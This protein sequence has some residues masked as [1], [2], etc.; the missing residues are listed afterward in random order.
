VGDTIS[1]TDTP[2]HELR[3][4][5]ARW[6]H[7]ALRVTDIDASIAWYQAFTPLEL[8]DKRQD[9]MGFGA[10]L[11]QSDSAEKP[12]ILVLAQFLPETDPFRAY[13]KEVLAPFAHFGIELP[14]HADIDA[15]AARADA[16]GCLAMKP[17]EMPDPIGYICMLRDPDGNMVEF[18]YDQGVYAKAREVWGGR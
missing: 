18:S 7:I 5:E 15:I 8:L 9:D 14:H 1:I 12:F 2:T 17:T 16:A 4:A 13:P 10:W 3:P 6:T 11:G